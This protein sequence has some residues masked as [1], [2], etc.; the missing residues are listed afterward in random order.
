MDYVREM[1]GGTVF[2]FLFPVCQHEERVAER[3]FIRDGKQRELREVH[4]QS[5]GQLPPCRLNSQS[6]LWPVALAHVQS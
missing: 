6:S 3:V 5:D 2:S 1:L 4:S